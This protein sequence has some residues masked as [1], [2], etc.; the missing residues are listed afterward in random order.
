M[1]PA[2]VASHTP[3]KPLVKVNLQ[4]GEYDIDNVHGSWPLAN[5]ASHGRVCHSVPISI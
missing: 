3:K 4:S 1:S 2:P 5:K